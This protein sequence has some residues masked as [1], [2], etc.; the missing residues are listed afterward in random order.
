M[1]SADRRAAV[2]RGHA[3]KLLSHQSKEP[4]P[5]EKLRADVPDGLARVLQRML[6]KRP[7]D[8]YGTPAEVAEAVA[9]YICPPDERQLEF[10]PGGWSI[11]AHAYTTWAMLCKFAR[12]NK[13][14]TATA[15]TALV[16]LAWSSVVNY[17]ARRALEKTTREA[18]PALVKAAQFGV[19]K[20]DFKNALDQVDLA[21]AYAPEN[22]EARL[23]KGQVLIVRRQFAQ[24]KGE[25]ERYLRQ[26]PGDKD[27]ER[28]LNLCVRDR[29]D[30]EEILLEL[31]HVFEQ[32]QMPALAVGL[33]KPI[34]STSVEARSNLLPMFQ[35]QI[36][37]SWPGLGERLKL[38]PNGIY[39]LNLTGCSQVTHLVPLKGIPLTALNL[40]K[41]D[42]VRDLTPL[43][44]MPLCALNLKLCGQVRDLSPLKGMQLSSVVLAECRKVQDLEPL[45]GMPLTELDLFGVELRDLR[46]LQGMQLT[47]LWCPYSGVV[48]LSPL[49]DMPLTRLSCAYT[50]VSDLSPLK[51][52][53]LKTLDLSSCAVRDLSP[54]ETLELL[55]IRLPPQEQITAGMDRL[56]KMTTLATINGVPREEFWKTYKK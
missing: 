46:P 39:R 37:R 56:R 16:L 47:S 29:P 33:L 45:R 44:G 19:E 34:A 23:L 25:L 21:L 31:A 42:G 24:A 4:P 11:R 5:I 14:F 55:E 40:E 3:E 1:V 10:D 49:K 35:A 22:S 17:Q 9:P 36:D 50:G 18:V 32:Q 38:D 54:L 7:E 30:S 26:Q 27:A 48:D 8:R 41:C 20:Q 52:M 2:C 6:A 43:R 51:G 13:A 15:V 12:R 28:L 53:P